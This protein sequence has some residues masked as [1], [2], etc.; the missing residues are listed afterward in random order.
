MSCASVEAKKEKY[1]WKPE[2]IVTWL[3]K[4]IFWINMENQKIYYPH[5]ILE[6]FDEVENIYF[7]FDPKKSKEP[8]AEL[9]VNWLPL[10]KYFDSIWRKYKI[11]EIKDPDENKN[12]KKSMLEIIYDIEKMIKKIY[13]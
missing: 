7:L 13:F 12:T 8:S 10:W 9:L 11:Y 3:L 5:E 4:E 2:K 1:L 6:K